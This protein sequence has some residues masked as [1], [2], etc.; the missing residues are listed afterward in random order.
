[1]K[2]RTL[3]TA[4][5]CLLLGHTVQAQTKEKIYYDKD[6]K[7]CSQSK[8]AY[9]RIAFF[10]GSG[11][12]V[13]KVTDYF[14]TGET[15]SNIEGA[16][17]IDRKDDK[18]S[19]FKGKS[20][21][22]YK[23]GKIH[24]EEIRNL[25]GEIISH[26]RW[27][28]NGQK[29]FEGT[30]KNGELD[31]WVTTYYENG[32]IDF[33]GEYKNGQPIDLS[34][35]TIEKGCSFY[36]EQESSEI[37][38]RDCKNSK[39]LSIIDEILSTASLQRNF[40]IYEANIGNAVA[41]RY[42]NERL[43]I[44]DPGFLQSIENTTKDKYTTYLII[45]HEIG[46]HLNAH[47]EQSKNPS[48][49]WDELEADQFAGAVLQKLGITPITI[50]KVT[51]LIA[52][53]FSN[54]KTHPEWQARMKAAINGYCQSALVEAKR[55]ILVTQKIDAAT[56]LNEE[57]KLEQLLNSKIYNKA[58][59]QRNIRYKVVNGNILKDF[60]TNFYDDKEHTTFRKAKDTINLKSVS[61][62][63][64]RWHDPGEVAFETENDTKIETLQSPE[65]SKRLNAMHYYDD[66]VTIADDFGLLLKLSE[67]IGRLQR[68]YELTNR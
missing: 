59:W 51:N 12:P 35:M 21:A 1:M 13:G 19:K 15:Q 2:T 54:S 56:M 24:F 29:Q 20:T 9:Y 6:W 46:H 52:P 58:D 67:I 64:L 11:K 14:I 61:K 39:T 17:Y 7:G 25:Q 41:T 49:W 57:K 44:V 10:D 18:N 53:E 55:K 28:E 68:Y 47:T 60:E 37:Y 16:I 26:T 32:K 40:K 65:A 48:P 34:P 38:V 63:Y 23:S 3:L 45:A 31:G 5:I 4:L 42:K 36:G 62:V 22:Y 50:N 27:H 66:D 43:I 30:Y 33:R 8:A